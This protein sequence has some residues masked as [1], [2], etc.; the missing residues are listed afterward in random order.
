METDRERRARGNLGDVTRQIAELAS[1]TTGQ[2]REK[3]LEVYGYES[4]SRNR[5][6]MQKKIAWQIQALA[7]GGLSPF[8]LERI[9]QL[10]PL[11]PI[12][13]R[14]SLQETIS[15][16][17]AQ[18]RVARDPRL[19]A[20]GTI[21]RKQHKGVTHEVKVLDSG[22]EYAGDNYPSLSKVARAIAGTPWNGFAF[23]CLGKTA[24]DKP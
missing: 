13:W 14:P 3:F 7:E 22:F 6:Y 2:L 5:V 24:A 17:E 20:A 1:M 10:A 23:F 9:E 15:P 18:A 4:G 16:E 12:R 19:P 21:L 8:A 11:A